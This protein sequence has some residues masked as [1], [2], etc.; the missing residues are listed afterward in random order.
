MNLSL[1]EIYQANM[2]LM[3]QSIPAAPSP[4]LGSC[5]AFVCLFSPRDGAFANFVLPGGRAFAN[6]GA[7]PELFQ[8]TCAVSY[9][10]ITT[11]RILLKKS[12]LAHL[13]RTGGCKVMFSILCMHFFIAFKPELHRETRELSMRINVF[14][15][16]NQISVNII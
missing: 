1:P 2:E 12:R 15:L 10:N 11:Q 7:I 16:V 14:W 6:L 8:D 4:C 13:S 9:Q 3:H 5:G